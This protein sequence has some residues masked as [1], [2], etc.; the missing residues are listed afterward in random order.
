[1]PTKYKV[2]IFFTTFLL[3]FLIHPASSYA[4]E[5]THPPVVTSI[6]GPTTGY[7]G[8]TYSFS[9]AATAG[10]GYTIT[11]LFLQNDGET[12]SSKSAGDSGCSGTSCSFTGSFTPPATG[13]YIIH[14]AAGY[15][16][17]SN[18]DTCNSYSGDAVTDCQN[19]G[20][21]YITF[22]VTT[23][24]STPVIQSISGP[25][26]GHVGQAYT[27]ST[28]IT[29]SNSYTLIDGRLVVDGSTILNV[30][31]GSE[32]CSTTDCTVSSTYTPTAAGVYHIYSY[33]GYHSGGSDL[34]CDSLPD[35]GYADCY[36]SNTK[37]ITFTVTESGN[38]GG[39]DTDLPSTGLFDSQVR[40]I[41]IGVGFVVT[42][43][44]MTQVTNITG[45]INEKRIGKKK[46]KLE[47]NFK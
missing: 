10:D 23:E 9:V 40:N 26:S 3:L 11:T 20:D 43:I 39:D 1:M 29:A 45:F 46:S 22:V 31:A 8:Q 27:F 24:P 38:G 5:I 12:F 4:A 13:T 37:Y 34:G 36:N 42:G 47:E 7:Y 21:K 30:D 17:G 32:G 2:L 16:T 28:R 25:T 6:S 19:S 15:T 18:S 44:L 14:A 35:N 33:T 41:F